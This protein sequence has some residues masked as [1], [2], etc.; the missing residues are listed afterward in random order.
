MYYCRV[1]LTMYSKQRASSSAGIL[2]SRQTQLPLVASKGNVY[3]SGGDER[4]LFLQA[5]FHGAVKRRRLFALR[6]Q[7][8][9]LNIWILYRAQFAFK[10]TL[11]KYFTPL[12]SAF[13][14][15]FFLFYPSSCRCRC[16]SHFRFKK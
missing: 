12:L 1:T 13:S 14:C 9:Y 10:L 6:I 5:T 15:I 2:C 11:K 8:Q 4:P 7:R 3:S 16:Y